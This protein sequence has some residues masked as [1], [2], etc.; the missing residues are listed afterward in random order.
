MTHSSKP[1]IVGALDKASMQDGMEYACLSFNRGHDE[2]FRIEFYDKNTHRKTDLLRG[3][4]H[5]DVLAQMKAQGWQQTYGTGD[6]EGVTN[7]FQRP[8]SPAN[9]PNWIPVIPESASAS[10]VTPPTTPSPVIDRRHEY[11]QRPKWTKNRA[12]E[13]EDGVEYM[14]I[15]FY[16]NFQGEGLPTEIITY[17]KGKNRGI[18]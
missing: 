12:E 1:R 7:Y 11:A 14:E 8:F 17:A 5:G 9:D 4:S 18:G 13:L 2:S 15:V 16:R 6:G 10:T 3:I